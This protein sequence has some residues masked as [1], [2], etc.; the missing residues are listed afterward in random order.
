MMS[1]AKNLIGL[2]IG[3]RIRY[4]TTSL[5]AFMFAFILIFPAYAD[6]EFT[7]NGYVAHQYVSFNK[8]PNSLIPAADTEFTKLYLDAGYTT[9]NWKIKFK[10]ELTYNHLGIYRD[11]TT[12]NILENYISYNTD[13]FGF[14]AGKK[15]IGWGQ[16]MLWSPANLIDTRINP[17]NPLTQQSGSGLFSLHLKDKQD[18]NFDFVYKPKM[19]VTDPTFNYLTNTSPDTFAFRL[20]GTAGQSDYAVS[21]DY[22]N[23]NTVVGLEYASTLDN[24]LVIYSEN[25]T[26]STNQILLKS[27]NGFR[28]DITENINLNMEYFYNGEGVLPTQYTQV[29]LTNSYQFV[30]LG[31]NYL[32]TNISYQKIDDKSKYAVMEINNLDDG[33]RLIRI[34]YTYDFSSNINAGIDY[35]IFYGDKSSEFGRFPALS[36]WIFTLKYYL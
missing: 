2:D 15:I 5:L 4:G 21:F 29:F 35:N 19:S 1:V 11:I 17:T 18:N 27:L 25:S 24:G 9:D 30:N 10:P 31:K 32:M 22:L 16:S 20:S 26:R 8:N 6:T 14:A 34:G 13:N 33:S 28:Y 12:L 3:C 23:P 36:A 7:Y